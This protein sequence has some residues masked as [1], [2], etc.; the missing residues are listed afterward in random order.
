MWNAYKDYWRNYTN[1]TGRTTRAGYWWVQLMNFL[2]GLLFVI[3]MIASAMPVL[4][5][6]AQD[7]PVEQALAQTGIGVMVL[8]FVGLL[9]ALAN[10]IPALTLSIRRIRDTGISGWWYLLSVLSGVLVN[11]EIDWVA[12]IG[13]VLSLVMLIIY[14]TPTN[15][16]K[17]NK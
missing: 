3:A 6:L 10:I 8:F 13:A 7:A 17:K 9:W 12:V 5:S 4:P 2:I 14:I 1:F 16:F 11:I 15:G